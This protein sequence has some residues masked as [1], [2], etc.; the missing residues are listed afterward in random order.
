MSKVIAR[1]IKTLWH[2]SK[3]DLGAFVEEWEI[4]CRKAIKDEDPLSLVASL[5]AL[6]LAAI[7]HNGV[8]TDFAVAAVKAVEDE[9]DIDLPSVVEKLINA[10]E[11][12][13]GTSI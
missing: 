4:L 5:G 10:L 12:D 7:E 3:S 8:V 13:D 9:G 2:W 11:I 6:A 1:R